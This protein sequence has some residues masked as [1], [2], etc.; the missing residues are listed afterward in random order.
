MVVLKKSSNK[1]RTKQKFK[2]GEPVSKELIDKDYKT[3]CQ[4]VFISAL[5]AIQDRAKEGGFSEIENIV[6]YFRN[7][8]LNSKEKFLCAVGSSITTIGLK[9]TFK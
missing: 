2:I 1:Y 7:Q 4:F 5:K 3:A 6:S 9:A 8:N